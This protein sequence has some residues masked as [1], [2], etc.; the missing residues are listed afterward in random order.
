MWY[1]TRYYIRLML[2]SWGPVLAAM[3]VM[4]IAS[5]QPKH[6]PTVEPPAIYFSGIMPVFPGVWDVLVKKSGHLIAYGVLALLNTRAMLLW[7]QPIRRTILLAIT[8]TVSYAVLDEL[9][10]LFVPG[11]HA[12]LMDIAIDLSGAVLFVLI[13]H[14]VYPAAKKQTA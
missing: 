14:R 8:F 9:H 7:Q 2:W 11:R 13:V 3:I 6:T 5:A 1:I 4:F 12:S 10:Q